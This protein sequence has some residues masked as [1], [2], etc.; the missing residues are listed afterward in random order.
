MFREHEEQRRSALVVDV[1]RMNAEEAH[2]ASILPHSWKAPS[3]I[4]TVSELMRLAESERRLRVEPGL[5][6]NDLRSPP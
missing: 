6:K 5:V 1:G 2:G 3:P 4:S